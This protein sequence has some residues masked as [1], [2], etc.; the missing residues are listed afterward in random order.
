M[1]GKSFDYVTLYN[2][3]LTHVIS[4]RIVYHHI[5]ASDSKS[6]YSNINWKFRCLSD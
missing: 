5:L 6:F 2:P 1:F 4:V 3:N